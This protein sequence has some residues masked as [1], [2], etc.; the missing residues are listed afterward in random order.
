MSFQQTDKSALF[1][2]KNVKL[3]VKVRNAPTNNTR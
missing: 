3:P 2:S 1:F